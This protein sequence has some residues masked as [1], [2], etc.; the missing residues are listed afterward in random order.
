MCLGIKK[1]LC[2]KCGKLIKQISESYISR[3][4]CGKTKTKYDYETCSNC[5]PSKNNLFGLGSGRV[6]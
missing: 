6:I 1:I 2:V 5:K 3:C 4:I